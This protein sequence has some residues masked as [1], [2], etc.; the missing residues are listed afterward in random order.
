M[1]ILDFFRKKKKA[2]N[3]DNERESGLFAAFILLDAADVS[4]DKF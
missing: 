1:G 2:E 3:K 4:M